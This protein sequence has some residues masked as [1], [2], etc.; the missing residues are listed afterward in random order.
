MSPQNKLKDQEPQ[1]ESKYSFS[2]EKET[3][4][5][6]KGDNQIKL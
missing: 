6:A 4:P 2:S 5:K 1:S 3:S